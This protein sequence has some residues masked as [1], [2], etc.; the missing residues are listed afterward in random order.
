MKLSETNLSVTLKSY[1]CKLI[2]SST[3][4]G[5]VAIGSIRVRVRSFC[6]IG[7]ASLAAHLLHMKSLGSQGDFS[8]HLH[9]GLTDVQ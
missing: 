1:A 5:R 8:S 2:V 7:Q 3:C 9:S 4:C 6:F